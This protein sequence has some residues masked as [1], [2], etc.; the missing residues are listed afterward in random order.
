[1]KALLKYSAILFAAIAL[2]IGCKKDS[3]SNG[4]GM[5]GMQ[6]RMVDAPADYDAIYVDVKDVMVT[7]SNSDEGW[8]SISGIHAG[9]YNLLD[10]TNGVDVLIA[11]GSVPAGRI[12]Q[13]RLV[14]GDNNSIVVDGTTYPLKTPSAQQSGL[15]INFNADLLAGQV[16]LVML[17]FDAS[18]SIVLNGNGDYHLKPVIRAFVDKDSGVIIGQINPAVPATV[19]AFNGVIEAGSYASIDGHFAIKGLSSGVYS[20]RID[21]A[22]GTGMASTTITNVVVVNGQVTSMGTIN[23]N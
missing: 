6:V 3:T 16:Y 19:T 2:F 1:M 14:L 17:D 21:P 11:D 4:P 15:K 23:L 7:T 22:P 13:I 20:V 8:V 10:L 12:N 5:A 18:K 9:V